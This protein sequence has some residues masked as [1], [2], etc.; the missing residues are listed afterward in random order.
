VMG[1]EKNCTF[2][3]WELVE[4]L[5]QRVAKCAQR[6]EIKDLFGLFLAPQM[7]M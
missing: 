1:G 7:Q 3:L 5:L 2:S 6:E 4:M